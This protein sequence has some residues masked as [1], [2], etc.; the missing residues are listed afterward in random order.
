MC[1]HNFYR[2][3]SDIF[4]IHYFWLYLQWFIFGWFFLLENL[5]KNVKTNSTKTEKDLYTRLILQVHGQ[6]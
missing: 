3:Q 2:N 1:F 6:N 5:E 4:V